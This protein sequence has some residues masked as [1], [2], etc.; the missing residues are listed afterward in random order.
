MS[1]SAGRWWGRQ[2][3]AKC[4]TGTC[5]AHRAVRSAP[6]ANARS[7]SF[8]TRSVAPPRACC[9]R[10]QARAFASASKPRVG[11][12]TTWP[13]SRLGSSTRRCPRPSRVLHARS[14]RKAGVRNTLDNSGRS[15]TAS[16]GLRARR[17]ASCPDR[18]CSRRASGHVPLRRNPGRRSFARVTR[19]RDRHRQE[20]G[21]QHRDQRRNDDAEVLTREKDELSVH[22]PGLLGAVNEQG[23]PRPRALSAA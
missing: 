8:Q 23:H 18:A 21:Q 4:R 10:L 15:S 20:R 11:S 9:R 3:A 6:R 19:Q 14:T 2:C 16:P 22:G 7:S 13:R 17:H 1:L 12:G 5:R